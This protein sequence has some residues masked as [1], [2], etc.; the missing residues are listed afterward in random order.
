MDFTPARPD[1]SIKLSTLWEFFDTLEFA[2][3][4][5]FVDA[6]RNQPWPGEIRL[7]FWPT[8]RLRT[9]GS[10]PAQ[11][12]RLF[13]TSPGLEAAELPGGAGREGGAF[14][15]AL[16]EGLAGTG[17]AKEW[18]WRTS[19]YEV[20]WQRLC[21]FV[22]AEMEQKRIKVAAGPVRQAFQIPQEEST[23]FGA[24]ARDDDPVMVAFGAEHF[25]PEPLEINLEPSSAVGSAVVVVRDDRA[26]VAAR[27]D[28]LPGL[29]L[30]LDLPP[31]RYGVEAE[32]PPEYGVAYADEPVELYGP[33]EAR[34]ELLPLEE[35][36]GD[37]SADLLGPATKG[38]TLRVHCGDPLG[39]LEVAEPSGR[40]VG[41][42][43]GVVE[44]GNVTPGIYVARLRASTGE[45]I[46]RTVQVRPGG[47]EDVEISA[48][49]PAS[50]ALAGLARD[51]PIAVA[52]DNTVKVSEDAAGIASPRLATIL[53]LAGGALIQ[54]GAAANGQPLRSLGLQAVTRIPDDAESG[55]YV[56]LGVDEDPGV[57]ARELGGVRLRHWPVGQPVP[58]ETVSLE[59]FGPTPGIGEYAAPCGTGSH[60]VSVER[61]GHE[62]L[63]FAPTLLPGR[64]A[65]L[66]LELSGP[67]TL[68]A[69]H[70]Q[71]A[72]M[73]DASCSLDALRRLE[74]LQRNAHDP[75][76]NFE[77]AKEL[78]ST[79]QADPLAGCLGGYLLV[80]LGRTEDLAGVVGF[81]CGAYPQLADAHVLAA[82]HHAAAGR[83]DAA[84][85]A[86]SRA[87]GAG[88]P[89]MGESI[90]RLL[91]GLA[92]FQIPGDRGRLA[93]AVFAHYVEGSL[94]TA[95]TPERLEPG[96]LL[97][98]ERL[99][100]GAGS[101]FAAGEPNSRSAFPRP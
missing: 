55:L 8:P 14:T 38:A 32:A 66:V 79:E 75:D 41:I 21:R 27:R 12:F 19:S 85:E 39:A 91:D 15:A 70:Y 60:W 34:L 82:E 97:L 61:D 45:V 2:N 101:G 44:I 86:V 20:R 11:Q 81:L 36:D 42:G 56:L 30:R 77:I 100:D 62:P 25:Q 46:E 90:S 10:P 16:L 87:V 88:V 43:H 98:P 4:F 80:R 83:R 1:N 24:G 53:A 94:W 6:C 37:E 54:P 22:Q 64:L 74:Y 52:P 65:M 33:C 5:L 58:R 35:D 92:E 84:R 3:Q 28:Q 73:P 99:Q 95:W 59:P 26:R 48:P 47:D 18:N 76:A 93:A 89:C 29:P 49:P 57:A 17:A 50:P 71:P 67:S 40:I 23:R 78:L 69:Y 68:R 7:G 63:V 9:L 72:L 51:T 96:R 13:A 31:R